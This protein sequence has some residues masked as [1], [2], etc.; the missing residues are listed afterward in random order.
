MDYG[1]LTEDVECREGENGEEETQIARESMTMAVVHESLLGSV[2]TYAVESKGTSETWFIEQLLEDLETVGLK[3]ER[4]VVKSD[5]EPAITEVMREVQRR[6]EADF[7]T[8][9]DNSRVGDSDSTARSRALSG[10]Q[11]AW[12]E[13]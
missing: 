7:G 13:H 3:N 1:F 2:W 12:P 9:I 5:Q 10:W 6:R 8:A 11:K 4:V